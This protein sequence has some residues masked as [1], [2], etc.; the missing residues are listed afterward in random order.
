MLTRLNYAINFHYVTNEIVNVTYVSVH[1]YLLPVRAS[2]QC[3]VIGLVSV[4]IGECGSTL[5]VGLTGI[6]RTQ[7]KSLR[8]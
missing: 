4:Y 6:V 5:Y 7:N 1:L 3:N 8:G 2:E